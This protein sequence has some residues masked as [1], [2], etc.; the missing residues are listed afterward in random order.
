MKITIDIDCTPQEARA[1]LGLPNIEPMQ[2]ELLAQLQQ[3]LSTYL[4]STD[5]EAMLKL[6]LPEGIKGLSQI[7]EQFWRQ[8]M[9]GMSG[10]TS[11]RRAD[12]KDDTRKKR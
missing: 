5:P 7:Q 2:D 12:D 8:F 4:S 3:Q 1:F 11:D 9:S 10:M 6:W